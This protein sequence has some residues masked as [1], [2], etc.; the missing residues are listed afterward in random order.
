MTQIEKIEC[1]IRKVDHQIEDLK[2]K[3]RALEAK[4]VQLRDRQ[5]VDFVRKKGLSNEE[6]LSML[7]KEIGHE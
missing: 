6:V 5:L 7:R 4:R 1:E 3:R 2:G